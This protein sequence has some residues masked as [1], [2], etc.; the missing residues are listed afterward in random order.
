M[1][2]EVLEGENVIIREGNGVLVKRNMK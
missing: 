2:E 1:G